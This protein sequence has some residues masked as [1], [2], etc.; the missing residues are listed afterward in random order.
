MTKSNLHGEQPIPYEAKAHYA[1][2]YGI[3]LLGGNAR[4]KFYTLLPE[5]ASYIRPKVIKKISEVLERK[6]VLGKLDSRL[7][8]GFTMI[9]DGIVNACFWGGEYPS[10]INPNVY[11]I[12]DLDEGTDI[13]LFEQNISYAGAFCCWELGI[14]A[15][16]ARAWRNYLFTKMLETDKQKYLN[17]RFVGIIR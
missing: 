12:G 14:V 17:D 16:E 1:G 5:D 7:G 4:V 8:L 9:S 11:R 10:L 15:H 13:A 3:Y 6:L 2:D